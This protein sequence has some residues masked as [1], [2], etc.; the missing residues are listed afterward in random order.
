MNN[1]QLLHALGELLLNKNKGI[2]INLA[3]ENF[4]NNAKVKCR[5]ETI[6]YY[7]K[8]WNILKN[9]LDQ[10]NITNTSDVNKISYNQVINLLML[11]GYKNSSINKFTDVLKQII[12][13]NVEL[14]Y[15][16]HSQIA[17]IKKLKEDIPNIKTISEENINNILKYM[18][19]KKPNFIN[20]RNYLIILLLNDTGARINEIVNIELKNIKNDF[21]AIYLSFTKTN[22][23]RWVFLQEETINTLK[24]Y[25]KWHNGNKYL[26][27][28][29]F[30]EQIKRDSIYNFLEKLK[31]DLKINQSITPHIWRHTFATN[32]IRNKVNLEVVMD[33]LGHT[34]YT[35]TKRYLHLEIE[36]RQEIILKAL[37]KSVD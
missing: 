19:N 2:S 5:T 32:L 25:L 26:L 3:Y 9:L 31:N 21:K 29:E 18:K 35:T 6:I 34:E 20:V 10:L 17:N 1:E 28:S 13:V 7:Q 15:I 8:K 4:I 12:K 36:E 14:E 37:K 23:P 27:L 30:G 24:T 16:S 33:V 22:K 11:K